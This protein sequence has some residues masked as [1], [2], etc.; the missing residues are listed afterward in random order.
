MYKKTRSSTYQRKRD[1]EADNNQGDIESKAMFVVLSRIL[2][3][4]LIGLDP[5]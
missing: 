4:I 2:L 3:A 5:T 1:P